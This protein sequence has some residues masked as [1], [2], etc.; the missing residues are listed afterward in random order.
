MPEKVGVGTNWQGQ[1]EG[2]QREP[3]ETGPEPRPPLQPE[4]SPRSKWHCRP[5]V[6]SNEG[7]RAA[8]TSVWSPKATWDHLG[9]LSHGQG[10]RGL[11]E[12][13]NWSPERWQG[14]KT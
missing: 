2:P 12:Q 13:D 9:A 5:A 4:V 6:S 11:T 10:P 8:G 1:R 7:L 3:V 14:R